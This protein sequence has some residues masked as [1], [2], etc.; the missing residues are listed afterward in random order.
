MQ[1]QIKLTFMGSCPQGLS[2]GARVS[3]GLLGAGR[4]MDA[5][6]L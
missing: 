1:K 4:K 5:V 6:T 2:G 3:R